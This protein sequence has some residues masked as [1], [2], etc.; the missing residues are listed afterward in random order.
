MEQDNSGTRLFKSALQKAIAKYPQL[1]FAPVILVLPQL[2]IL[3]RK[4]YTNA[5][6]EEAP[7]I[8]FALD[9]TMTAETDAKDET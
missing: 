8:L 4:K 2:A 3:V 1:R 5:P 6:V 7:H 9:Q